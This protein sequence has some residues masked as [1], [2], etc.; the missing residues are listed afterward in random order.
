MTR[1]REYFFGEAAIGNRC[2]ELLHKLMRSLMPRLASG[3]AG[4]LWAR[5][6]LQARTSVAVGHPEAGPPWAAAAA[7]AAFALEVLLVAA[8]A[9][10]TSR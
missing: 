6:H 4:S 2:I 9:L 1:E 5:L 8:A 3:T 7:A 10:C